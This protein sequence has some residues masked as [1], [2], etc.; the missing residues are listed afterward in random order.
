[1]MARP[2][3]LPPAPPRAVFKN[4]QPLA[5][6]EMR[7]T[8]EAAQEPATCPRFLSI[9][10][11]DITYFHPCKNLV[12]SRLCHY[13]RHWSVPVKQFICIWEWPRGNAEIVE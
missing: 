7:G 3:H 11:G 13:L 1:M 4:R 12:G 5:P 9:K 10:M 6:N 2:D 8:S